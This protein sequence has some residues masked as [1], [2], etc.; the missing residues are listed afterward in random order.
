MADGE[1]APADL[2]RLLPAALVPAEVV[3]Q[4]HTALGQL[5]EVVRSHRQW[6]ATPAGRRALGCLAEARSGL[7]RHTPVPGEDAVLTK[8][9]LLE[10][11]A[12]LATAGDALGRAGCLVGSFAAAGLE[13]RL[14]ERLVDAQPMAPA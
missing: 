11:V 7:A 2:L 6:P 10:L 9:A 8:D 1:M 13:G 14:L 5:Q 12:A 4:V 3:G